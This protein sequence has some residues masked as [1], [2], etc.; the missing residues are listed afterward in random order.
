MTFWLDDEKKMKKGIKMRLKKMVIG[1]GPKAWRTIGLC[2]LFA[3][4]PAVLVLVGADAVGSGTVDEETLKVMPFAGSHDSCLDCHSRE[5]METAYTDPLLT[6]DDACKK[7]H[8]DMGAHHS[9]GSEVTGKGAANIRVLSENRLAC[10][11]CHDLTI[12]RF[13]P[14]ARKAQSLFKR[15]FGSQKLYK[16]YYLVMD[17][18]KGQLCKRCH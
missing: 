16:T 1:I 8:Q 18:R 10:I 9:T 17:N 13:S 12:K 14:T 5:K 2:I 7:C 4:V 11:S 3:L 15:V 6:C